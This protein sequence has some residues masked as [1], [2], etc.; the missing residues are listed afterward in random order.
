MRKTEL[1][2]RAGSDL[3]CEVCQWRC[4]LADTAVGRCL[5]RQRSG[6]EIIPLSDGLV[7]AATIG[8]IEDYGFRH[9][10]P[11]ATVFAVGGWGT[12]FPAHQDHSHHARIPEDPARRREIDPERVVK[13][14]FDRLTRGVIWAYNDPV[15]T[16]EHMLETM[17]YAR[18]AGRITGIVTGGYWSKAALDQLGP[19]LDGVN[20]ILHGFSDA[21]YQK[22]TGIG[23]W[24][25]IIAGAERAAKHWNCHL[26]LTTPIVTGINDNTSEVEA[27]IRWIQSRFAGLLPWRI[28]PAHDSDTNA[29]TSVR[30]VAQQAGL[31]FIYGSTA[32]ETTKC[33]KCDWAVIERFGGQTRIVGVSD[34]HCDNCGADVNIRTSLFKKKPSQA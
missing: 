1:I 14:S 4:I 31:P 12:P 19:Y 5:V 3:R 25:G 22:L 20:L 34:S 7:S 24:R 29:A 8:P 32:T 26:E 18:S 33:P 21:S 23:E 6:D 13:F 11:D 28:I 9:F 16:H 15:I 2:S 27:I 17:R 10:F 30:R